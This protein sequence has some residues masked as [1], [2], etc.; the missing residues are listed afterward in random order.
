M[1]P[2]QKT[3]AIKR[4]PEN[5]SI[6][7]EPVPKKSLRSRSAAKKINYKEE[8]S[9]EDSELED[10][11]QNKKGNC[12]DDDFAPLV[13]LET[14]TESADDS[15]DLKPSGSQVQQTAGKSKTQRK[16][17]RNMKGKELSITQPILKQI[18]KNL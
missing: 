1:P 17:P 7:G 8:N 12:S 10:G 18:F 11:R 2:K 13:K 4:L 3:Q 9:T 5:D 6:S 15:D 16:G 14:V